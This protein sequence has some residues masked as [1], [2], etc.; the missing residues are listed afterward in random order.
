MNSRS[1]LASLAFIITL[2]SIDPLLQ[3]SPPPHQFYLIELAQHCLV[4]FGPALW[5]HQRMLYLDGSFRWNNLCGRLCYVSTCYPLNIFSCKKQNPVLEYYLLFRFSKLAYISYWTF[6]IQ[7]LN[8]FPVSIIFI[9]GKQL[10]EIDKIWFSVLALNSKLFP[11][12]S[13]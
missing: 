5:P 9:F 6:I 1:F 8:F 2:I 3:V 10:V 4:H 13:F 12:S 7:Q 11:Y